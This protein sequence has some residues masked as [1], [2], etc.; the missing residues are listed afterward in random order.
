VRERFDLIICC[1]AH[2]FRKP[3]QTFRE[4][5]EWK[6]R[7]VADLRSVHAGGN[8][9]EPLSFAASLFDVYYLPD[10]QALA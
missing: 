5:L 9:I 7:V 4:A 8:L 3:F 10:R 2:F 6:A 1:D